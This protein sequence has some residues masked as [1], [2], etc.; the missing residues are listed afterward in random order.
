MKLGKVNGA[1]IT[2]W[3]A[4]AFGLTKY[5]QGKDATPTPGV[6]HAIIWVIP[7]PVDGVSMGPTGYDRMAGIMQVDLRYPTNQGTGDI[8]AKADAIAAYFQRGQSQVYQSQQVWFRGTSIQQPIIEDGWL[9]C[10]VDVS[11]YTD[12]ARS[13]T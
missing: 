1:L 2:R 12:I 8:I 10:I 5:V 11:W 13:A 4:G 3:D 9:K 7:S 6:K